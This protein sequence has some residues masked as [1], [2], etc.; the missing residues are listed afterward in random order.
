[1]LQRDVFEIEN[2]F[3]RGVRI[4]GIITGIGPW[5]KQA[6]ETYFHSGGAITVNTPDM[7]LAEGRKDTFKSRICHRLSTGNHEHTTGRMSRIFLSKN[8]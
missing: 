6:E 8:E 7:K 3:E 1:M 4:L 5:D 2:V